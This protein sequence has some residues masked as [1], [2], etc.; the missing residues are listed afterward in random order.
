MVGAC[1]AYTECK[2]PTN[3]SV[4]AGVEQ[5]SLSWDAVSGAT[6]YK[7]YWNTTGNVDS[8]S[9][10]ITVNGGTTEDHISLTGGTT[11]YYRVS[12][13]VGGVE[14]ALSVQ[15]SAT[16]WPCNTDS[17]RQCGS[18]SQTDLTA[19]AGATNYTIYWDNVSR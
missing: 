14:S 10:S 15:R 1:A 8:S 7:I 19:V 9:S 6:D 12:S 13:V 3:L 4:T 2:I 5:N 16:G 11:Y 17:R 18:T